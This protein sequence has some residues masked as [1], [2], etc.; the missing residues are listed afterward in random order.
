MVTTGERMPTENRPI[1]T[2]IPVRA[3]MRCSTTARMMP[4]LHSTRAIIATT[5]SAIK[6]KHHLNSHFIGS[7]GL[8][9]RLKRRNVGAKKIATRVLAEA[10]QRGNDSES[11]IFRP[12]FEA[13]VLIFPNHRGIE[14]EQLRCELLAGAGEEVLG[15]FGGVF[16]GAVV[17]AGAFALPVVPVGN[18][19]DRLVFGGPLLN[20][21]TWIGRDFFKRHQRVVAVLADQPGLSYVPCQQ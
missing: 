6:R 11:D 17:V 1:V 10:L 9:K 4:S 21:G 18:G 20:L 12:N 5:N 2:S 14:A 15:F 16:I 3:R 8:L 13:F 7:V 19:M